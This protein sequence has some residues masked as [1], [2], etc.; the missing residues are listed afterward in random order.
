MVKE[1]VPNND[2]SSENRWFFAACIAVVSI[3]S[4]LLLL[5]RQETATQLRMP[6][7]MTNMAV[8]LSN[9]GDE[10][11]M[12]RE[13]DILGDRVF[14]GQLKAQGIAPFDTET[15]Y[16]GKGNCFVVAQERLQLRLIE[17]KETGEWKTQWRRDAHAH[18][19]YAFTEGEIDEH[20]CQYEQSWQ[21]V[22]T[23]TD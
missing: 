1:I 7:E 21:D 8:Q 20:F 9:A 13:L 4:G 14:K 23:I 10:I 19:Y 17:Q 6:V 5:T 3:A 11:M 12:L 22:V 15:V 2:W 18:P 16:Q